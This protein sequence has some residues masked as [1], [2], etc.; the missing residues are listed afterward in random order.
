MFS[1]GSHFQ[2]A[3]SVCGSLLSKMQCSTV[4]LLFPKCNVLLWISSFQ[5]TVFSCGS[6]P[7]KNTCLDATSSHSDSSLEFVKHS[8]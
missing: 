8:Q 1:C 5:I 4:D 3:V 7:S 2:Y 6:P